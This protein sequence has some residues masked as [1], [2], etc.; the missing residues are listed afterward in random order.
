MAEWKEL[1]LK[2][3]K[4]TDAEA[5]A[6]VATGDDYVKNTGDTIT[7]DFEIDR[8]SVDSPP[9][10]SFWMKDTKYA[11]LYFYEGAGHNNVGA[12]QSIGP[13]WH[14]AT[15]QGNFEIMARVNNKGNIQF[16]TLVAGIEAKKWEIKNAGHVFMYVIRS[17]ATQGGAGAGANELWKTSEHA[18]L[19]DN[20]VMI[21]V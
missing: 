18:T 3:D 9:R 6:A 2:E 21:G 20:V 11:G 13:N 15:R 12:F 10:Q 4:Y 17:G 19:P 16:F 5:V 14:E 8:H 1:Q 7:G